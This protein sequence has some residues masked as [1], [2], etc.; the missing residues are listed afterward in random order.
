LEFE[1][2]RKDNAQHGEVIVIEAVS[3][4]IPD[5]FKVWFA[6]PLPKETKLP[7]LVQI[8]R[9]SDRGQA[10]LTNSVVSRMSERVMMLLFLTAIGLLPIIGFIDSALNPRD[11]RQ[12]QKSR[13][14]RFG[15]CGEDGAR[16]C[17]VGTG[18]VDSLA[19]PGGHLTGISDVSAEA[20]PKRLELLKQIAPN[21]RRVALLWNANDLGMTLRYRASEAGAQAL[22]IGVQPLGVREPDAFGQA[23]EAM[24]RDIPDAI[25]MVTDSPNNGGDFRAEVSGYRSRRLS[26][27]L[28]SA[29]GHPGKR[30][31]RLRGVPL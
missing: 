9:R 8:D 12:N 26:A 4:R 28:R 27:L 6:K 16:S 14:G 25:L 18:R 7:A 22:G 29:W 1:R 17:P 19:R 31:L 11:K 13:P 15:D 5:R 3:P 20:T 21:L 2:W 24:K 23:F 10:N 30:D